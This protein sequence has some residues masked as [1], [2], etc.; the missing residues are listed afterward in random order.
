MSWNRIFYLPGGEWFVRSFKQIFV[1][2]AVL[3]YCDLVSIS[4]RGT[5]IYTSINSNDDSV[6]SVFH[7]ILFIESYKMKSDFEDL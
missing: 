7:V 5:D 3:F 6:A 2:M 4:A 1:R